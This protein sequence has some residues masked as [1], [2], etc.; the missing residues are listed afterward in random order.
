MST[1]SGFYRKWIL[2]CGLAEFIGIG[3]AAG[4]AVFSQ[5]Y[6]DGPAWWQRTM[7]L[8]LMII[9]GSIEGTLVGYFQWRV[10]SLKFSKL[11]ARRWIQ[12]TIAAAV[13]A[14][15]LGMLPSTLASGAET[16]S[17]ASFDPQTWMMVLMG[18]GMGLVLGPLF[19][20]FQWLELR[21]HAQKSH[22]W[23]WA[24]LLG[25]MGGLAF[26]F[27]GAS[28]PSLQ[29]PIW[30][31]ILS[32]IAGGLTGGLTVGIITGWFLT[33]QVQTWEAEGN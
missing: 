3:I 32:A 18:M 10:L 29:T 22:L 13:V 5:L 27:L 14:W 30:G 17:D 19:G 11:A 4:F 26:I 2:A 8:L 7:V 12:L 9:A 23:I 28:L 20:F 6:V 33:Y 25:W 31:I 24:N 15:L 21:R 1:P 16:G